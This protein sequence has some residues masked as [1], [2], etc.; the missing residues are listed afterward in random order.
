MIEQFEI[1]E[2]TTREDLIGRINTLDE[3]VIRLTLS[4][5]DQAQEI[6]EI[7]AAPLRIRLEEAADLMAELGKIHNTP[8]A[9]RNWIEGR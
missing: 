4:V 3:E 7:N 1:T 6:D 9:K 8:Q 5:E 2:A